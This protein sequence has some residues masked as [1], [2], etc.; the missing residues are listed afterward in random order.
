M[1][2]KIHPLPTVDNDFAKGFGA[3]IPIVD[4]FL[5]ASFTFSLN[6]LLLV[7]SFCNETQCAICAFL[8]G[9]GPSK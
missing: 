2:G 4:P 3:H 1:K 8:P 7:G 6:A 9:N 5:S